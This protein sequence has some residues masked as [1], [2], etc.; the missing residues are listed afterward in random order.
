MSEKE[1]TR[2]ALSAIERAFAAK[3]Q[4]ELDDI[5]G[6]EFAALGFPYFMVGEILDSQR[7]LSAQLYFGRNDPTWSA[8]YFERQHQLHDSMLRLPL[9]SPLMQQWQTVRERSD[10]SRAEFELYGEAGE[11][12]LHDGF[13]TPLHHGD[14]SVSGVS[15]IS[16]EKYD[17]SETDKLVVHL[18][19]LYYC[20]IGLKLAEKSQRPQVELTPRQRECLQWVHLGKTSA[21]I[22]DIIGISERTVNF[23]LT[24]AC[25]AF[26]VR[27]RRQ[28]VVEALIAGAIDL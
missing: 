24:E 16:T 27:T 26:S 25:K 12:G 13:V 22:A 7:K 28:A 9:M 8:H 14:G 17:L 5:I 18:L 11:F 10:L 23:H 19:S 6:A 3:T 1:T 15:V 21:E 4:A 20:C 2:R